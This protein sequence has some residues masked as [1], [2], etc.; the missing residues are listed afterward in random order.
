MKEITYV[1]MCIKIRYEGNNIS[2][3]VYQNKI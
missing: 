3:H 1:Y 2:L